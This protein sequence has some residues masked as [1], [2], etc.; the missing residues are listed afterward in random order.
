MKKTKKKS[1]PTGKRAE[2]TVE[3]S[4]RKQ[5]FLEAYMACGRVDIA[6]K[7]IGVL[8]HFPYHWQRT[9]P[10]FA[11][12]WAEAR[13]VVTMKLEDAAFRRGVNGVLKPIY[14]RGILVGMERHFSDALLTTLLRARNPTVFRDNTSVEHTGKDGGPI[15]QETS[16][17]LSDE[18]Y[19]LMRQRILGIDKP[20]GPK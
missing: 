18:A 8:Y 11:K 1:K 14:Q 13:N 19:D 6:T 20:E 17:G 4:R 7:Q 15:K 12:E 10:E 3:I 9:D 5:A 2:K 16:H